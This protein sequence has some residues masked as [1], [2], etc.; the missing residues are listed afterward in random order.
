MDG[1]AGRRGEGGGG[2]GREENNEEKGKFRDK[3]FGVN[4]RTAA[5]TKTL[6]VPLLTC[7]AADGN[8][9]DNIIFT[10]AS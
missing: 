3:M 1:I 7:S 4:K 2:R 5:D 6:L 9:K 8:N 10:L